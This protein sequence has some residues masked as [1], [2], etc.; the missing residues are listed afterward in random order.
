MKNKRQKCVDP[1]QGGKIPLEIVFSIGAG[2]VPFPKDLQDEPSLSPEAR[3][4]LQAC[5]S[6]RG[7]LRENLAL[8][9]EKGI[10]SYRTNQGG[11]PTSA[12]QKCRAK[13]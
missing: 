1:Q 4:H 8:W 5:E 10:S 2:K 6:C 12:A 11:W 13:H 9:Y 3:A 7:D